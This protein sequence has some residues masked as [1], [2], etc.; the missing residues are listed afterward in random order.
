MLQYVVHAHCHRRRQKENDHHRDVEGLIDDD[1]E[2][3]ERQ[4]VERSAMPD[5]RAHATLGR[6]HGAGLRT[7]IM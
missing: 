5:H 6:C 2:N 7:R 3:P 4:S 1:E